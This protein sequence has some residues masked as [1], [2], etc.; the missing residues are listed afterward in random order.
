MNTAE[1]KLK[2]EI[3]LAC[4]NAAAE[5]SSELHGMSWFSRNFRRTFKQVD[6]KMLVA[7]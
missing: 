1:L 4:R 5:L 3:E 7:A 2:S 6:R